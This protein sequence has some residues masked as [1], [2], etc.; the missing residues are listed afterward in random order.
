AGGEE[1]A[2]P[3]RIGPAARADVAPLRHRSG[4][5]P[6]GATGTRRLERGGEAL[7]AAAGDV[8]REGGAGH[9]EGGGHGAQHRVERAFA[10]GADRTAGRRARDADGAEEVGLVLDLEQH[11]G[12][13][14]R[15]A[16]AEAL[17]DGGEPVLAD[18]LDA[19]A[20]TGV[21]GA[22]EEEERVEPPHGANCSYDPRVKRFSAE[23][24]KNR[25]AT[26][27]VLGRIV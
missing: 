21:A 2:L 6:A 17:A 4:L 19:G 25:E 12:D 18:G 11:V 9:A 15:V 1:G 5:R 20:A 14:L 8:E 22:A 7:G 27:E 10:A 3:G 13:G 16:G 26:A 23:N 24:E